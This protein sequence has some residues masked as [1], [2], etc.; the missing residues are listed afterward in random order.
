M[1]YKTK[2]K[3]TYVV[4]TVDTAGIVENFGNTENS[5]MI[6]KKIPK[7]DG[8]VKFSDNRGDQSSTGNFLSKVDEGKDIIWIG[9]AE[10]E[11]HT[12]EIKKVERIGG[13]EVLR[14]ESYDDNGDGV[15]VGKIRDKDASILEP[16]ETYSITFQVNNT[17]L[18]IIDPQ[19]QMNK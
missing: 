12:V 11:G 10:D 9:I 3:D 2:K 1:L 15:V 14:K 17:D 5:D 6:E 16:K 8:L 18:Y 19:M 4:V 13:D 7:E